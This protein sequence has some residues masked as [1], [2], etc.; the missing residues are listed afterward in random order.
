MAS[1]NNVFAAYRE[2]LAVLESSGNRFAKGIAWVAGELVP[3]HKARMPL[4]D[5]GFLHSDL[6][7]DVASV[8]D[9]RL[10]RFDDHMSRLRAGCDKLRLTMPL[11]A[12]EIQDII[13]DMVGR[14]GIRDGLVDIIVTRGMRG[15]REAKAEEMVSNLYLF[16]VPYVWVM[17]PEM[18]YFGG[19]AI[20]ARTVR[21]VPPGAMDPVVKNLQ[22]GDLVRSMFE[23]RDRG[24]LY[25]F[26]TDGDANLTEGAG[27]NIVLVK[28]GILHTA[29]RGVLEG[30]TR[31][32][33]FGVAKAHGIDVRREAVPVELAYDCD[34][35]FLTT[36]AG[37]IMPVTV[38]DGKPVNGGLVGP[39]SKKM[40][41][42]Y[43]KLHSDAAMTIEVDYSN[44]DDGAGA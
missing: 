33:V 40:W 35:I 24:A 37:G 27:F 25:A 30:I 19:S 2:R 15:V 3:V 38:L 4:L 11:P 10:F 26:L 6:T 18:Q 16:V 44:V 31:E 22:W 41:D 9:G 21:R 32:T 29:D 14:S 39:V 28:D 17:Q 42:E 7:Y 12:E 13:V 20:V 23:A 8:W 43:W 34:E 1:M 5:Q 36:T